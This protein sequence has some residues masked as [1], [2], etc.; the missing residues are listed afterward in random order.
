MIGDICQNFNAGVNNIKLK[1]LLSE[2]EKKNLSPVIRSLMP[3][4]EIG[5]ITLV[6]QIV[7]LSL[8][9]LTSAQRIVEI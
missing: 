2:Q 4:T 6:D 3:P 9:K 8:A 5:S 1:T 7:L